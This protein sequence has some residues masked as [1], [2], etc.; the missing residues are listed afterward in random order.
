MMLKNYINHIIKKEKADKQ[1]EEA[2][3][4]TSVQSKNDKV[5]KI[6]QK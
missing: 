6:S 3:Q 2:N 4:K 1:I 5:K